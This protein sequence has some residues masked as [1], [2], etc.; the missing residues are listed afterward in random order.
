MRQVLPY[1]FSHV[2][3]Q[4]REQQG[5]RLGDHPYD[6]LARAPSPVVGRR[7]VEAVLGDVEVE[8]GEQLVAEGQQLL[9]HPVELVGLVGLT[10]STDEAGRLAE[11]PL[12]NLGEIFIRNTILFF[13]EVVYVADEEACGVPEF[14]V[15]VKDLLDD[16]ASHQHVRAV[17]H[18]RHPQPEHIRPIG[19]LFL[20]VA[21]ALDDGEGAEDVAQRLAHFIPLLVQHKPVSQHRLVRRSPADGNRCQQRRLEPSPVLVRSL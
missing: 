5:K 17:I 19:R 8:V 21:A 15:G 9:R 7:D 1:V 3:Q 18:R 13:V 4:G 11:H 6:R 16:G 10:H 20:L 2:R 14:A 12:V